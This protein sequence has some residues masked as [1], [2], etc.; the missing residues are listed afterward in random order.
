MHFNYKLSILMNGENH[1]HKKSLKITT[2]FSTAIIT[3]NK[4]KTYYY[5]YFLVLSLVHNT[6]WYAIPTIR[7]YLNTLCMPMWESIG[8]M[9]FWWELDS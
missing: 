2:K 3:I 7:L 1:T 6:R 4:K 5:Y 8:G 9:G